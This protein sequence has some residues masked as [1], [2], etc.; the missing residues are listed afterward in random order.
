PTTADPTEIRMLGLDDKF[1]SQA[2][3]MKGRGCDV[4]GGTGYK[5]R[6]GIYEIFMLTDEMQDLIYKKVAAATIRE[7]ARKSGMRTLREDALRKAASGITTLSEVIA[8][9]VGDVD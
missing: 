8:A 3:L 5:G 4:C 2:K 1:L 7:A 6:V 9:T